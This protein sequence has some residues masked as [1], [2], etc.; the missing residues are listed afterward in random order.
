MEHWNWN[1]NCNCHRETDA[2]PCCCCCIDSKFSVDQFNSFSRFPFVFPA[3][4]ALCLCR[5]FCAFLIAARLAFD[6]FD[7]FVIVISLLRHIYTK[8]NTQ[9]AFV[10]FKFS[11]CV[12]VSRNYLYLCTRTRTRTQTRGERQTTIKKLC[13]SG[14]E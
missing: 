7:A 13:E 10:A 3:R 9:H 12:R 2:F 5:S 11:I 14:A 6:T 4:F 1:W 8:F